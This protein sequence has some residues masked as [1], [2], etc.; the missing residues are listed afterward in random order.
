MAAA[1]SCANPLKR[2]LLVQEPRPLLLDAQLADM[3]MVI[4]PPVDNHHLELEVASLKSPKFAVVGSGIGI[5]GKSAYIAALGTILSGRLSATSP[6]IELNDDAMQ[7]ATTQLKD[8]ISKI[9]IPN[10]TPYNYKKAT[11]GK[12]PKHDNG[13]WKDPEKEKRKKK[14]AKKARKKNRAAKRK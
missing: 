13:K 8:S 11:Q 7:R 4:M 6:K 2:L 5:H 12:T 10:G 1:E 14:E 9:E 3:P